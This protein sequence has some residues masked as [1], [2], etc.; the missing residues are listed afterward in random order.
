V[1]Y[2]LLG[3]EGKFLLVLF[4]LKSKMHSFCVQLQ[5]TGGPLIC[6]GTGVGM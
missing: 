4:H 3:V 1:P 6:A 5:H 2:F